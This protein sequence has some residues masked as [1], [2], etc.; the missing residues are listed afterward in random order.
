MQVVIERIPGG[1]RAKPWTDSVEGTTPEE[2][3]QK[4]LALVKR[5]QET[6]ARFID[7]PLT[8]PDDAETA[9][10]NF[11]GWLKDDP[12]YDALQEAIEER[13]RQLDEDPNAF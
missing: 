1:Y 4:L 6:G 3:V 11:A 7:V 5:Y 9:W 2:A 10:E 12:D 8:A 13:R